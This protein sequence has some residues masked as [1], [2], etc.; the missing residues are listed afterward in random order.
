MKK[1]SIFENSGF[2]R[3]EA[4]A[5]AQFVKRVGWSEIRQNAA[6]EEEAYLIREGLVKLG[7]MLAGDG[8]APR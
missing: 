3:D 7:S 4:W 8:Y 2:S 5:L 1:G 6:S